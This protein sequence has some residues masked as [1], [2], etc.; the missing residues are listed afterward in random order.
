[1]TYFVKVNKINKREWYDDFSFLFDIFEEI[2]A[3][4][5]FKDEDGG[6]LL[7]NSDTIEQA[8]AKMEDYRKE[9]EFEDYPDEEE[10]IIKQLNKLEQDFKVKNETIQVFTTF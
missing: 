2:K 7:I 3:M 8:R 9:G 10:G 5:R 1:M 4:R 6:V